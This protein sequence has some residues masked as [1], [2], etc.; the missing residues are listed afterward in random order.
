MATMQEFV[1]ASRNE[2][3]TIE[4]EGQSGLTIPVPPGWPGASQAI[5]FPG[6]RHEIEVTTV[7]ERDPVWIGAIVLGVI[8]VGLSPTGRSVAAGFRTP[9]G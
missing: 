1:V 6:K 2:L 4:G 3:W 7:Q 5:L 9:P 8:V